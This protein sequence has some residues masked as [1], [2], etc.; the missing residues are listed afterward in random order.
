MPHPLHPP[1]KPARGVRTPWLIL[2]ALAC[3]IAGWQSFSPSAR[4]IAAEGR[5]I[6]PGPATGK[7]RVVHH[8]TPQQLLASN[9]LAEVSAT[10]LSAK[11][12]DGAEHTWAGLGAG[13]PLVLVFVKEGCPCNADFEP[14]FR[15]VEQ[16]Y[17]DG[18]R[19]ASVI[20][21]NVETARAY[22]EGL[23]VPHPVLADPDRALIRRFGAENGGY[24]ALIAGDGELAALWPGCS[25]DGL[26]DLGRRIARLVGVEER[27]LDTSGMPG[28]LITGCPFDS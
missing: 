24:V 19:F 8:V 12:H 27:P 2:A 23:Q 16:L 7:D 4:P 6:S 5:G 9:A 10:D 28:P 18:V 17:G 13:G 1:G 20:D 14:F 11:G 15:R 22:A 25:A 21:G 26:R 3:A